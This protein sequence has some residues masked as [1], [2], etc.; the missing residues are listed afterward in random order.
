GRE[1][2]RPARP[3]LHAADPDLRIRG[4]GARRHRQP[5]RRGRRCV[6][7][8]NR[9]QPAERLC[10]R[11]DRRGAEAPDRARG[12]PPRADRPAR[13]PLRPGRR[14]ASV[15]PRLVRYLV[16]LVGIVA[17]GALVVLIPHANGDDFLNYRF[18]TVGVYFIALLGLSV[19]TGYNGQ[20]SLGH[21]AFLAVGAYTTAIL[22]A[23]YGVGIYWTIPV[24]GVLTGV[25][26]FL[27]GFPALR[28]SGVYLALAT[29]GL[30]VS[31]PLI[32]KHFDHFTGGTSPG[33]SITPFPTSEISGLTDNEWFSYMTWAV[34]ALML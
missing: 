21:G 31:I 30:A 28:L 27:F 20:I 33:K 32:V 22:N 34:A 15:S 14:E 26:G 1:Q 29:F 12:A 16:R 9:D 5:D 17:V 4:G 3:Q 25:F 18:A 13:R 11:D 2:Q 23:N 24:A 19:L 6:R 8:R 10:Q 7:P